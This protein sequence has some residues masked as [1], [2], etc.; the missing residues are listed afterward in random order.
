M[1]S[2][3]EVGAN[4]ERL[5]T[6]STEFG[7]LQACALAACVLI[8]FVGLFYVSPAW[9]SELPRDHPHHVI[10]R[11]T[12]VSVSSVLSS[13]VFYFVIQDG[14]PTLACY[15]LEVQASDPL[16]W[17]RNVAVPVLLVL[18]LYGAE[19]VYRARSAVLLQVRRSF[20]VEL[21]WRR[22]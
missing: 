3:S 10:Y 12:S 2:I 5:C 22:C 14:G 9:I 17:W 4:A 8:P 18:C 15:G 13:L 21:H 20:F 19:I 7:V 16:F 1:A 11:L 6:S